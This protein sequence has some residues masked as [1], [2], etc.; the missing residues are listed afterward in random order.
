MKGKV[1]VLGDICFM[2]L[3]S[4]IVVMVIA[5]SAEATNVG[6]SVSI[7]QP[8]FYGQ[9]DIGH[10]P[11]PEVIYPR[12]VVVA[13]MPASAQAPPIYLN[14]PPGHAK[15]WSKHCHRYNACGRPV[16]FVK[17]QWYSDV[18]VPEYQA[19]HGHKGGGRDDHYSGGKDDHGDRGGRGHGHGKGHDQR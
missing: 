2:L 6:V 12:P 8:G 13:Q 10:F 11:R 19:R 1:F 18:Y 14:V 17:N 7:G 3:V 5:V 16:Y 9:I 15:K 4:C